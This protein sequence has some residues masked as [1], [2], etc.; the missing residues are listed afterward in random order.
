MS[1]AGIADR[2]S[3]ATGAEI[4]FS[5]GRDREC[6]ISK[7]LKGYYPPSKHEIVLCNENANSVNSIVKTLAHEVTHAY[8]ACANGP[9]LLEKATPIK[10]PTI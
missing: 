4:K 1:V 8:Q 5:D 3:R 6:L 7:Y 10:E 2:M 9:I